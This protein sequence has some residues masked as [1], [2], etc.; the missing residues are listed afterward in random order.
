MLNLKS[1][2]KVKTVQEACGKCFVVLISKFEILYL[3][4]LKQRSSDSL[5]FSFSSINLSVCC[6]LFSFSCG[7]RFQILI[8]ELQCIWHKLRVLTWLYIQ[9]DRLNFNSNLGFLLNLRLH[10]LWTSLLVESSS[11][12]GTMPEVLTWKLTMLLACTVHRHFKCSRNMHSVQ[13][14]KIFFNKDLWFI[15]PARY[16]K[17]SLFTIYPINSHIILRFLKIIKNFVIK[18]M[19]IRI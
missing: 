15:I 5:V 4:H 17:N 10:N 16:M 6:F 11:A 13:K 19:C 1:Q 2:A 18:F 14:V 8:C 9:F 12:G 3:K 7:L